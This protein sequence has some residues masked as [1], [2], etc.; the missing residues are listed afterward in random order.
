MEKPRLPAE[1]QAA[2]GVEQLKK[3]PSFI[4]KRRENWDRLYKSLSHLDDKLIL[5]EPS[6]NIILFKIRCYIIP[7]KPTIRL[8]SNHKSKP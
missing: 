1:M 6:E 7:I 3:F 5:P 4:E 2:I 8:N